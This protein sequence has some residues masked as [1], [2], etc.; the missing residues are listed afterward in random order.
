MNRSSES[1]ENFISFSDEQ[2]QQ[3]AY[4]VREALIISLPEPDEIEH[5]FSASFS[6]KI[7]ALI[8][9][10]KNQ[11]NIMH[12]MRGVAAIFLAALIGS[13]LWL[14]FDAEVR[15]DFVWWVRS[16]YENS[17][18]YE[19]FGNRKVGVLPKCEFGWLPDGYVKAIENIGEESG[20][21]LFTSN[22]G[23]DIVFFYGYMYVGSD[24]EILTVSD[25][26]II[27]ESVKVNGNSADFYL[28]SGENEANILWW[29]DEESGIA[30]DLNSLLGKEEMI[31]IAENIILK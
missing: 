14:S 27:Y 21:V 23:E 22:D 1:Y 2:L 29:I 9:R 18:L 5:E 19:Y 24:S 7:T 30:F 31:K 26:K 11:R 3:A 4:A 17:V 6:S 13:G 28:D 10:E 15:A 16:V 20:T 25:N 12:I 8:K